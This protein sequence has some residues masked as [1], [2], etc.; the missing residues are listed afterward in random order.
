[1]AAPGTDF[2]AVREAIW[3]SSLP[4]VARFVALRMVEHLP[5]VAPSVA[6]L[7]EHTGYDR[8]SVIRALKTLEESGCIVVA[9]SFGKRSG[10]SLT[11]QWPSRA[12]RSRRATGRGEQPVAESDNTSRGERLPPVAESDT[13][14]TSKADKEAGT[15]STVAG[16]GSKLPF[17]VPEPAEVTKPGT[18][19]RSRRQTPAHHQVPLPTDWTP[20]EAHRKYA[21]EH[22]LDLEC[23]ADGLR[24]WAEGRTALSW[25]GTFSTRLANAAKWKRERGGQGRLPRPGAGADFNAEDI[26]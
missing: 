4:P 25:N 22:G 15:P 21:A 17:D 18:R 6:S 26:A 13:K 10:Y 12:N 16:H 7:A 1:M 8:T 14:Q 20:T 9:R 11:G 5:N 24:G 2:R 3:G 19:R 23:E